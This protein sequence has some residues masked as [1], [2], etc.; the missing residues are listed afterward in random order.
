MMNIINIQ[1]YYLNP[2]R[3]GNGTGTLY[4]YVF[5]KS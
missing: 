3:N 2:S 1:P 5:G 4:D